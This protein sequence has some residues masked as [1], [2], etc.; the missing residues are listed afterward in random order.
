[1]YYPAGE[2]S[3]EVEHHMLDQ[4]I[5]LESLEM[6]KGFQIY[7]QIYFLVWTTSILQRHFKRYLVCNQKFPSSPKLVFFFFFLNSNTKVFSY[8]L[9]DHNLLKNQ[10]PGTAKFRGHITEILC[11]EKFSKMQRT[12]FCTYIFNKCRRIDHWEAEF[13]C[14]IKAMQGSSF[15]PTL[16]KVAYL[17]KIYRY[18]RKS[19]I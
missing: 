9:V 11:N 14:A 13:K 7:Q 12:F 1:M 6:R 5:K 18:R 19:K 3:L 4:R 2:H 15:T 16:L 10:L 8:S 17:A